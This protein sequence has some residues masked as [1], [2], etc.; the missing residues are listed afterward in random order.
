MV[1]KKKEIAEI[2]PD[3]SLNDLLLR[4]RVSDKAIQ[5][6]MPSGDTVV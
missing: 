2:E 3:Y 5:K 4:G 6:E 1:K